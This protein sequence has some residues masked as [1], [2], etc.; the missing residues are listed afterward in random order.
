VGKTS[1]LQKIDYFLRIIEFDNA[2]SATRAKKL[3]NGTKLNGREIFADYVILLRVLIILIRETM[4]KK[5]IEMIETI[6]TIEIREEEEIKTEVDRDQLLE[7]EEVIYI[8]FGFIFNYRR[9]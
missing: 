4:T 8:K 7:E 2:K 1:I 9:Q 5:M 3:L 6:E